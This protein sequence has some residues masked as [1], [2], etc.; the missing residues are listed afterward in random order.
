MIVL[1]LIVAFAWIVLIY[2]LKQAVCSTNNS[3]F[4]S[5]AVYGV[6]TFQHSCTPPAYSPVKHHYAPANSPE[7]FGAAMIAKPNQGNSEIRESK[8]LVRFPDGSIVCRYKRV[9]YI[10]FHA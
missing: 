9:V 10:S 6:D 2:K 7:P 5:R 8:E 3:N 1:L 4:P